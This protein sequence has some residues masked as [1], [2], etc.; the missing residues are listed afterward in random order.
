MKDGYE[1]CV[2]VSIKGEEVRGEKMGSRLRGS[3]RRGERMRAT[4][5]GQEG[6][7]KRRPYGGLRGER[8]YSPYADTFA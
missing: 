8:V 5:K 1:G 6:T 4:R 7:H 2:K 3:K